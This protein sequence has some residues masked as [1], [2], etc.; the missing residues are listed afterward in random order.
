MG[1]KPFTPLTSLLPPG[2]GSGEEGTERNAFMQSS[3][4]NAIKHDGN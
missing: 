4:V 3:V 2:E 1:D